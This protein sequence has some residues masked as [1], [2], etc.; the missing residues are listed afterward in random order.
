[1]KLSTTTGAFQQSADHTK[2]KPMIYMVQKCHE[3]GYNC[4]DIG[5][6]K[7]FEKEN[8]TLAQDNWEELIDEIGN[9][10]AK[11]GI[12]FYQ[13]HTPFIQRCCKAW[14]DWFKEPGFD[15]YYEEMLRRSVLA[16]AKLGVKW[17]IIHPITCPEVNYERAA[18]I[19]CNHRQFDKYVELGI[20]NGVGTCFENM[21]PFLER[22]H[23]NKFCV[24]YE[25]L[26]DLVD[27]FNDPMV[28]ICYDTGHG[29]QANIQVGRA[30]RACG[31]RLKTLHIND[32]IFGIK[33]EH[34][35]PFMGEVNWYDFVDALVDVDYQGS[36][37]YEAHKM[38]SMA[39][40]G[41]MQM[42][43]AKLMYDNGEFL[44]GL[45]NEA[46]TKKGKK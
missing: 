42:M 11:E 20:K 37:N 24:H 39:P 41:E 32:N 35:M 40:S 46:L 43:L 44:L 17:Q 2:L 12:E 31:K 13:S 6:C 18:S 1:M 15:E 7:H 9:Y 34:L 28:Q 45:Y 3:A 21:L 16:A 38:S 36:L 33:D 23:T 19:E 25:E 5:F 30:I 14:D 29:N 8:Y 4:I 26:I 10:A 22:N 27:S